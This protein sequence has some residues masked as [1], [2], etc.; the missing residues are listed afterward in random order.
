MSCRSPSTVT[1]LFKK[2]TGQSFKQYQLSF[3][4][5]RAATL[6]AES[7]DCPIAEIA[8]A[9]GFDDPL[10]FSRLFRKYT[11]Q[12]PTAYRKK[13]LESTASF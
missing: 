4:L 9:V 10:Y 3:R 6:M 7:P 1:R 8:P 2:L 5:R 11:G 13:Q 12:S